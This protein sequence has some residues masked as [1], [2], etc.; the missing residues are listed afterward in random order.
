MKDKTKIIVSLLM[1]LVG[2]ILFWVLGGRKLSITETG[3]YEVEGVYIPPVTEEVCLWVKIVVT[4]FVMLIIFLFTRFV[5]TKLISGR[6]LGKVIPNSEKPK[7][8]K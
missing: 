1:M 4:L 5:L 3:G 8:G 7:D 2:G 6:S